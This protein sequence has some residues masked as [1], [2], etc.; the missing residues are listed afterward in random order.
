MLLLSRSKSKERQH[1]YC[2]YNS[3]VRTVHADSAVRFTSQIL[4]GNVA[5]H[6][7]G[8]RKH[9]HRSIRSADGDRSSRGPGP[10]RAGN[11]STATMQTARQSPPHLWFICVLAGRAHCL[12]C[13]FS[14][15]LPDPNDANQSLNV[16][17]S[18]RGAARTVFGSCL[19]FQ[20]KR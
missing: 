2:T 8:R 6:Q 17:V 16:D 1:H 9:V 15:V 18:R 14:L 3:Y 11:R 5:R 20:T 19:Y 4:Y 10:G 12:A 7:A 13:L